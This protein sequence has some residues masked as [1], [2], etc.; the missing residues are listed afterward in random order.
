MDNTNR[1]ENH[2]GGGGWQAGREGA[3]GTS[4]EVVA[5]GVGG[6]VAIGGHLL[7]YFCYF[8]LHA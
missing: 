8:F 5:S 3:H 1:R 7:Y 6:Q 4:G 2:L